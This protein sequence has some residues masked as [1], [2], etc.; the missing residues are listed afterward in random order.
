MDLC[1]CV[2]LD[3]LDDV[4]LAGFCSGSGGLSGF[5]WWFTADA[6]SQCAVEP[7]GQAGVS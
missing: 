4:E 6:N 7:D 1:L 2:F 3:W 5:I